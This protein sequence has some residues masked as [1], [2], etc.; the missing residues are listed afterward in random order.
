[1]VSTEI[2]NEGFGASGNGHDLVWMRNFLVIGVWAVAVVKEEVRGRGR[3]R[4]SEDRPG[5]PGGEY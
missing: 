2:G 3:Q 5:L 4:G 1:M